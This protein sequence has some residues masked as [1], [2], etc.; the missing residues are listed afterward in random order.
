[1]AVTALKA[2][3]ILPLLSLVQVYADQAADMRACL[4]TVASGLSEGN[5]ADAISPFVKS[6]ANYG[7]LSNYFDGLTNAFN[8]VSEIDVLD[9]SD[10]PTEVKATVHWIV[11]LSD[12]GSNY[13][14][15]RAGDI[16]VRLVLMGRKWKIVDF[17]P[18]DI[19]DPQAKR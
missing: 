6:Y 4:D 9:E 8:I 16:Q 12:L 19:F 11:T 13:T 10:S 2:V 3:F 5:P 18:I 17:S 7:T 14:E 1:M 15:R